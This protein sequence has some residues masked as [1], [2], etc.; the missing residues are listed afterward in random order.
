M[1]IWFIII[2]II[3]SLQLGMITAK[4]G[5]ARTGTYSISSALITNVIIITLITMAIR[6]GF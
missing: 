1:N 6:T 2:I 5:E 3:I 4:D